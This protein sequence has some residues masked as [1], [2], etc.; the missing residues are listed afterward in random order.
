LTT[1]ERIELRWLPNSGIE[2]R[3]NK[4]GYDGTYT[5]KYIEV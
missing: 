3:K 1:E 5:I 4:T 2:V